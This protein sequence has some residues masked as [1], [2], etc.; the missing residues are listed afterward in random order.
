MAEPTTMKQRIVRVSEALH[1]EPDFWDGGVSEELSDRE[2]VA[3]M[4]RAYAATGIELDYPPYVELRW[5]PPRDGESGHAG[6]MAVWID[7]KLICGRS[8]EFP[9]ATLAVIDQAIEAGALA[10][11]GAE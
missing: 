9:F 11:G 3:L 4:E 7:G 5:H 8:G 6:A 1:L 2:A 10:P